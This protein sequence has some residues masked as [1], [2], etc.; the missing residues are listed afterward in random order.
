VEKQ[1][2]GMLFLPSFPHQLPPF[3]LFQGVRMV[4][5]LPLLLAVLSNEAQT[6]TVFLGLQDLLARA[7]LQGRFCCHECVQISDT[8]GQEDLS[9]TRGCAGR[10]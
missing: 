10:W 7:G 4:L 8:K 5:P 9:R 6:Q 2:Q 3:L 1:R